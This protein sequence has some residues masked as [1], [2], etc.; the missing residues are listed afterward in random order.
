M[1]NNHYQITIDKLYREIE[2]RDALIAELKAKLRDR[3]FS[4][5]WCGFA[6]PFNGDDDAAREKAEQEINEHALT[7]YADPR[8][9]T[10]ADLRRQIDRLCAQ[11]GE[12]DSRLVDPPAKAQP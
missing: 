6:V 1:K 11:L 4:C 5:S 2:A 10:I 7:C 9:D 12:A 8:M 3:Y